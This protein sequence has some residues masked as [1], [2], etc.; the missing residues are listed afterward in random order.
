[1]KGVLASK[2]PICCPGTHLGIFQQLNY[3]IKRWGCIIV[4]VAAGGG[5]GVD[6]LGKGGG[7]GGE[8]DHL[9]KG[10]GGRFCDQMVP[11]VKQN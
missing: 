10:G 2:G 7:G 5:G 3:S 8:V 11:G 4:E 6:H 1:M 9:G